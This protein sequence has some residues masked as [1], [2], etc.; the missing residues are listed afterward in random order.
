MR[1]GGEQSDEAT[2]NVANRQAARQDRGEEHV[3]ALLFAA[4]DG[5]QMPLV[6]KYVQVA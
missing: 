5:R 6:Q 3:L 2:V 4:A 1:S